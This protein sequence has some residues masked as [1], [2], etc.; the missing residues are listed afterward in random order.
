MT[1]T[2]ELELL[3]NAKSVRIDE[4][5]LTVPQT[6]NLQSPS[7]GDH[8]AILRTDPKCCTSTCSHKTENLCTS[9]AISQPQPP[10][11]AS[12]VASVGC[13]RQRLHPPIGS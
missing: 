9:K 11:T 12:L 8:V 3:G 13:P 2:I 7:A 10:S 5:L 4:R 6:V 1:D